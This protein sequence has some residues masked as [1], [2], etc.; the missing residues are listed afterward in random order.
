MAA[1]PRHARQHKIPADVAAA[2]TR[3]AR[4]LAAAAPPPT[5]ELIAQLR[6]IFAT[7]TTAADQGAA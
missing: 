6:P 3:R 4:E 2:I 7:T 1:E 5:P